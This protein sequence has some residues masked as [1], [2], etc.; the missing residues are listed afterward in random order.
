MAGPGGTEVDRISVRVVPNTDGFRKSLD[1]FIER[2]ERTLRI[3]VRVVPDTR[4]FEDAVGNT[5]QRPRV[6]VPVEPDFDREFMNR[7]RRELGQAARAA[8][9]RIPL[10]PDGDLLRRELHRLIG[11]AEGATRMRFGADMDPEAMARLRRDIEDQIERVRRYGEQWREVDREVDRHREN[12][13]RVGDDIDNRITNSFNTSITKI[14]RGFFTLGRIL[15]LVAAIASPGLGLIV[16]LLGSIPALVSAAG[17]AFAAIALGMDGIKRAA[18]TLRPEIDALKASL[19][20]EWE[21]RLSPIFQ[22]IK[23]SGIFDVLDRGLKATVNGLSDMAQGFTDVVTSARGMAQIETILTKT[24]QFFSQLTGFTVDMTSAFLTMAESGASNF[25]KLS[26]S[27]NKFGQDFNALIQRLT[28]D[29]TFDQMFT[30]LSQTF[31]GLGVMFNKLFEAGAR[32]MGT[33]GKPLGD[34]M[35]S[36]GDF[37]ERTEPLFTSFASNLLNIGSQIFDSLGPILEKMTPSLTKLMDLLGNGLVEAIRIFGQFLDPIATSLN[38]A[39]LPAFKALEPSLPKLTEAFSKI[40]VSLGTG[41]A[42]AIDALA[43]IL[44]GLVSGLAQ[45]AVVFADGLAKSL[46]QIMPLFVQ[47]VKV[48][49]DFLVKLEPLIP[50]LVEFAEAW[51]NQMIQLLPQLTPIFEKLISEVLPKLLDI[52]IAI[53]PYLIQFLDWFTRAL[54]HI[55]A[56]ASTILTVAVPAIEFLLTVVST[57]FDLIKGIVGTVLD[58][59]VTTFRTWKA[60]FTGDWEAAWNETT[61]F[62]GRT[63][64]RWLTFLMDA[65]DNFTQWFR[66][67]PQKA[68]DALGDIGSYLVE[69]GKA[70]IDGFIRGI[71]S[72]FESAKGAVQSGLSA[73]RDLFPFSP[74]K[75]GPFSGQGWVLYSGQSV[76]EAFAEGMT[77]QQKSIVNAATQLM[78]AAKEVFGDTGQLGLIIMVGA[79]DNAGKQ[80]SDTAKK[81]K[82]SATEQ[83]TAGVAEN[84]PAVKAEFSK[85]IERAIPT[86]QMKSKGKELALNLNEGVEDG[87]TVLQKTLRAAANQIGEAFGFEDIGGKWDKAAEQAKFNDIPKDFM[88]STK[89][90]FLSDLGINGSGFLPQLFEQGAKIVYNVSSVEEVNAMER[91]RKTREKSQY[92]GR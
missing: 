73:I 74:A 57:V 28:S 16:G 4:G 8:G 78:Q 14:R 21:N 77:D 11:E 53:L 24:G 92:L 56:F 60:I 87:L 20:Q 82:K 6:P 3:R 51:V 91:N 44:P 68:K 81:T 71:N 43:P 30:G 10:T 45:L 65:A 86:D 38:N 29:G 61:N 49:A 64:E 69:S 18:Q 22:Q 50:K 70:L 83:L 1:R 34:F 79:I 33:I 15:L 54:P 12:V 26:G 90:Q 13:R 2:M 89:Q 63:L 7:M 59:L 5:R 84:G 88:E 48:F 35:A 75:E 31:D 66:D 85:Q 36:F 41:F 9:A 55:G 40:A 80:I 27:L 37:F 47:L 32:A 72:A 76:G 39:L 17:A 19:S 67:L 62:L 42:Q 46:P 58:G 25:G 23:D 52:V